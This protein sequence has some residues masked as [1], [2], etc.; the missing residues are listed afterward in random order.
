MQAA[1]ITRGQALLAHP[2]RTNLR[3]IAFT[4]SKAAP[5][6]TSRKLQVSAQAVEGTEEP[7]L[8]PCS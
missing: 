8:P 3:H 5:R 6:L 1:Q 4:S 2:A 7:A